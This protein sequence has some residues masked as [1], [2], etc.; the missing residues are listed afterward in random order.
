MNFNSGSTAA[1]QELIKKFQLEV[2]K[3]FPDVMV[4]PYTNGMFRAW[5]DPER[6]IHAG[7]KGV[8]D[9]LVLGCGFYLWFDGKTGKAKFTKEQKAFADRIKEI[10]KGTEHVY[11]L[12][13]VEE[14]LR[15]IKSAKE[16]YE[17][18]YS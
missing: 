18:R 14:G 10:N 13:S 2:P 12:S 11:K 15:V 3:Q 6:V 5:D 16:F 9:I 8:T 4:L 1:H 17:K 7:Q